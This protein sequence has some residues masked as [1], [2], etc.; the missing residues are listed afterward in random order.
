MA[1]FQSILNSNLPADAV[2]ESLTLQINRLRNKLK[3]AEDSGKKTI[4]TV[5][6]NAIDR[7][8]AKLPKTEKDDKDDNK[9]KSNKNIVFLGKT[10][11]IG[12]NQQ[13]KSIVQVAKKLNVDVKDLKAYRDEQDKTRVFIKNKN[14]IEIDLKKKKPLLLRDFGISRISNKQ[15]LKSTNTIKRN[16]ET[17]KIFSSI[18]DD[19]TINTFVEAQV[20]VFYS[21]EWELRNLSFQAELN[22]GDDINDLIYDVAKNHFTGLIPKKTIF[23]EY[24]RDFPAEIKPTFENGV[25]ITRN[26]QDGQIMKIENMILRDEA[27]PSI[28]N[29]YS[30]VIENSNWK[31]CVHDYMLEVYKKQFSIKTLQKLNTTDDIYNFCKEKNIK[32][33]AYDINGNCIKANYPNENRSRLKN[34]FFI[35]HNNHLYPLKSQYLNKVKPIINNIII[36]DNSIAKINE[37]IAQGRYVSNITLQGSNIVSFIDGEIKYICN[38][39]YEKCKEILSKFGLLD[40][41]YDN[42]RIMSLGKIIK[43]LYTTKNDKSVFIGHNKFVKG[44]FNYFNEELQ[45]K[46]TTIDFN[47]FYPSC[48]K[49]LNFLIK[50]DMVIDD[51]EEYDSDGEL[52]IDND[53]YLYI[54]VPKE[55]SIL[56]PDTNCYSGEFLKY[57]IMEGLEFTVLEKIKT[58]RIPNHY[59]TMIEDLYNKLN[60]ADFKMI[61]NVLI[62]QFEAQTKKYNTQYVKLV[63]NDELKTI[64]EHHFIENINSN[65]HM[66]YDVNE[67]ISIYNHKPIAIQ[68]K[69][70]SRKRLYE[71]MKVL[72]LNDSNIKAIKTDSI[73]Y[74]SNNILPKKYIGKNLG[75]LKFIDYK[76]VDATF[77]YSNQLLS[78][79]Y[80]NSHTNNILGNCYAGCGKSYK[81]INTHIPNLNND[82]IILTPSHS[83]LKEYRQFN[84]NCNVI[85]S[86]EFT[87][88]TPTENNIIIDEIGMV[89]RNGMHQVLKW[90]Y[91]GKRII[92]Y[93]DF[94]QLL[95]VG[96]EYPLSSILFQSAIFNN[97]DNMEQNKRNNFSKLFYDEIIQGKLNNMDV[98]KK[99]RNNASNNFICFTNKSCNKYNKMVAIKLGIR[100]KFAVGAK[101]ICNTNELRKLNI[102]N[103]FIFTVVEEMD[104]KVKLDNGLI[105]DKDIM[106]KID[107]GKEYFTLA[108]ARTLH[109]VQ[110]E[111]LPDFYFPD[112]DEDFITDRFTYTLISRLKGTFTAYNN[113]SKYIN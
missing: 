59:K 81:I 100:D 34:L 62:G 49:D 86:Y 58:T 110:G 44:G 106:N 112:D 31:H 104:T 94:K 96:E 73:S 50:V 37:I 84:Y 63:N 30:N 51:L 16:N 87:N 33:I 48:L 2:K 43:Q 26:N 108:Y 93:G 82:Y 75:Q 42:I 9:N 36:I 105:I 23:T 46:I 95:P 78:F 40:K 69:D 97:I 52:T 90:F 98:I 32:M 107:N 41:I 68:I 53:H 6:K 15:L 71:I 109:S 111:S 113:D 8:T 12:K 67:K 92:A 70:E 57:C 13:Y 65:L 28:K 89:S 39:E 10:Y 47:K 25:K 22:K 83:S 56:L 61:I 45:G 21:T 79:I 4:T 88:E 19:I 35:A 1:T 7:L 76:P 72:K 18:P 54:V 5:L 55:S 11:K 24:D 14:S 60:N 101:I 85:Q 3:E 102:F 91:M 66:V 29:M 103:K 80:E 38:D 17:I 27:P 74:I 64:D 20:W 99:Y 77:N